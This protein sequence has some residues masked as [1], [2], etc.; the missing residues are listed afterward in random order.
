[1][2]SKENKLHE[3]GSAH[4]KREDGMSMTLA[5]SRSRSMILNSMYV[6]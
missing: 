6:A 1:M 2:A 5:A 3:L 4:V